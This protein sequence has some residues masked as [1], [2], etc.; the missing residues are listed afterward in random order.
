[1][2]GWFIDRCCMRWLHLFDEGDYRMQCNWNLRR[3]LFSNFFLA[4]IF[5]ECFPIVVT[6]RWVAFWEREDCIFRGVGFKTAWDVCPE[7]ILMRALQLTAVERWIYNVRSPLSLWHIDGNHKL[8]RFVTIQCIIEIYIYQK[9][10]KNE[11]VFEP[12]NI[13]PIWGWKQKLC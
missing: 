6:K 7:G 8:I 3:V 5:W 12:I 9:L 2:L 4:L 1:M 10:L 13:K 11:S